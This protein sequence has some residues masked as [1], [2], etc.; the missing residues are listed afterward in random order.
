MRKIVFDSEAVKDYYNG[1]FSKD[2]QRYFKIQ[3]RNGIPMILSMET[4]F[5]PGRVIEGSPASSYS[6][7]LRL[8]D[9]SPAYRP[10][11][12]NSG[13]DIT[14]LNFIFS[15]LYY[16][17]LVIPQTIR[18]M[19]GEDSEYDFYRC[20]GWPLSSAGLGGYLSPKQMLSE[21]SLFPID[22]ESENYC[23]MLDAV[24]PF[25]FDEIRQFV[26]GEASSNL[27]AEAYN[28]LLASMGNQIKEY[29]NSIITEASAFYCQI[30]G[31][32]PSWGKLLP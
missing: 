6:S 27:N 12:E 3:V 18:R 31:V 24:A 26:S 16:F 4:H 5:N 25:M 17:M 29:I 32:F 23:A 1:K 22:K 11:C 28:R 15:G 10:D 14:Q 30:A 19:F 9:G 21:A 8:I 13:E 7:L 2:L 20:K